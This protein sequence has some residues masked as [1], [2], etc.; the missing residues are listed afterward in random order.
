[1]IHKQVSPFILRRKKEEV[2]SDLPEKIEQ[3]VWV[4]M[5]E[6]QRRFYEN[7]L[8]S[9]Q[10]GILQKVASDGMGRHRMEVLETLL[11]LRQICCHPLLVGQL[12]EADCDSAKLRI[13]RDDLETLMEEG[14]KVLVYSQFTSMLQLMKR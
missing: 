6:A 4:E 3:L 8:A 11:R 5:S 13:L 14:K 10:A 7:F 12:A 9:A 2:A 1:R